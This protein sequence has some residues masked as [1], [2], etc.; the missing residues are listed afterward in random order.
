MLKSF[1]LL[2]T[3]CECI[4]LQ[5]NGIELGAAVNTLNL[6]PISCAGHGIVG[7]WGGCKYS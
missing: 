5:K 7:S 6:M 1:P 2:G 3:F 4:W